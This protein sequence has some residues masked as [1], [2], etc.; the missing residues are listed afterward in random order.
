M[1]LPFL[2]IAEQLTQ[3]APVYRRAVG[4]RG[5][6]VL[7]NRDDNNL[8]RLWH[9]SGVSVA[10]RRSYNQFWPGS[11]KAT[12]RAASRAATAATMAM[13]PASRSAF[14]QPDAIAVQAVPR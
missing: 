9:C 2:E 7:V 13:N 12:N 5:Q 11:T 10:M 1:H 14:Y 6:R 4:H 3:E 8:T